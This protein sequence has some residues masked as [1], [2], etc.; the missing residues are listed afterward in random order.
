M[1]EYKTLKRIEYKTA[2]EELAERLAELLMMQI[3]RENDKKAKK[4]DNTKITIKNSA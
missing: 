1:Q 4:Y 3:E 2:S